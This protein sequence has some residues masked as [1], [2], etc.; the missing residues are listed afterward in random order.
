MM[1]IF[2]GK[3]DHQPDF[4]LSYLN[5][6]SKIIKLL[7]GPVTLVFAVFVFTAPAL[8]CTDILNAF[9]TVEKLNENLKQELISIN[10]TFQLLDVAVSQKNSKNAK[11]EIGKLIDLYFD[12]YLKYYQNP[13]AQFVDDP[14]WHDKLSLVNQSLKVI[15]EF[16]NKDMLDQ[17]HSHIKIAYDSF[18]A[19]YK[20]RVPMQE[21]NIM[22]MIVSKLDTIEVEMKRYM[23]EGGTSE[24]AVHA[25]NLN[26]LAERLLSFE[27]SSEAYLKQRADFV[28][29][30][31]GRAQFFIKTP[32]NDTASCSL[33]M[34]EITALKGSLEIFLGKRKSFLNKDWFEQK[35]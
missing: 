8:A 24:I 2:N 14:K 11:T 10:E 9:L 22:D 21:Q 34:K 32:I 3:R 29:I 31:A 4:A 5:A 27:S 7:F 26:A 16:V 28:S 35:K 1:N 17:A 15:L 19:I 33:Q 23:A 13:P 30:L 12:F 25:N 18:S 6:V 20:D